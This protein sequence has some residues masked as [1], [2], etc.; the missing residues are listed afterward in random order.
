MK[1]TARKTN[2]LAGG[3]FI[4]MCVKVI[5]H[6]GRGLKLSALCLELDSRNAA[7]LAVYGQ[8]HFRRG[9]LAASFWHP[10]KLY[11]LRHE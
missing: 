5:G 8:S 3:F 4:L 9:L 6:I 11:S 10:G 7:V 2:H 1:E